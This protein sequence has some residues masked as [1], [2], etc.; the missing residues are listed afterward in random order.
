MIAFILEDEWVAL[1]E[2]DPVAPRLDLCLVLGLTVVA[3]QGRKS[4]CCA[5]FDRFGNPK[6]LCECVTGGDVGGRLF[7]QVFSGLGSC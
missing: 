3:W 7:C 2:G 6:E 1:F 5:A 4:G